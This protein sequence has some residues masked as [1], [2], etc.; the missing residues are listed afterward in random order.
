MLNSMCIQDVYKVCYYLYIL[1]TVQNYEKPR[2]TC[3]IILRI[4][5]LKGIGEGSCPLR[6]CPNLKISNG[7]LPIVAYIRK[8]IKKKVFSS[9]HVKDVKD[10]LTRSRVIQCQSLKNSICSYF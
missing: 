10:T 7:I 6:E 4:V 2:N 3:S 1:E 9:I 5:L 8:G